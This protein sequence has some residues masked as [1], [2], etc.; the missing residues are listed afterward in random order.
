MSSLDFVLCDAVQRFP[1]E[2]WIL[3]IG[4]VTSSYPDPL[5]TSRPVSF[6]HPRHVIQSRLAT[7]YA[8]IQQKLAL[9]RVS[10]QWNEWATEF[11][12]EF[13]WVNC[14]GHARLLA[15]TLETPAGKGHGRWIRRLHVE[16]M[17]LVKCNPSHLR[18][19]LDASP[20]LAIYSDCRSIRLTLISVNAPLEETCTP[21]DLFQSLPTNL[22]HLSWT[23]YE[24]SPTLTM[25]LFSVLHNLTFLELHFHAP[26]NSSFSVFLPPPVSPT[27]MFHLPQLQTLRT[28]L[29][30]NTFNLL[31]TW[32]L[33]LLCNLSLMSSDIFYSSPGFLAFF[34]AHGAKIN[35]LELGH[36][37]SNIL[38]EHYITP[39]HPVIGR[40][41]LASLLPNLTEFICSADFKW[42]W[43]RE[44]LK[45]V[46]FL[47]SD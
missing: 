28:S 12:Y 36:S 21:D 14:A 29:C 20:N 6:L 38:E 46:N 37:S 25:P 39:H 11:L 42:I 3:I 1:A 34:S 24:A 44:N 16:T 2:T 47:V 41:S 15:R 13:I 43:D 32:T 22:R 30:S 33:P 8:T 18:T 27:Q 31:S 45:G 17:A 4:F 26:M 35:Q 40:P 23:S 9:C 10:K 19:I 7:Y 5:D